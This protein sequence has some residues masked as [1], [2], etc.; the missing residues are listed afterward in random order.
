MAYRQL[1]RL[2]HKFNQLWHSG[3][4]AHLNIEPHVG[5]AWVC[6]RVRLGHEP[7][8]HEVYL[9]SPGLEIVLWDS[10]AVHEHHQEKK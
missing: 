4:S 5:E 1:N 3:K 9:A 2:I 6:L 7:V 10:A 8:H